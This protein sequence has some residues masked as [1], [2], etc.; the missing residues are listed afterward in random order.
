LVTSPVVV[1]LEIFFRSSP[2]HATESF[3]SLRELADG[4]KAHIMLHR[5]FWTERRFTGLLLILGCLLYY[6]AVGLIPRDAQGNFS[7]SLPPRAA[8]LIIAAQTSLLQWS[9]SLFL[10]GIVITALGFTLL[11]RLL[12]DSEERT[13][14][15]LALITSLFGVM[16]LLIYLA[17]WVGVDPFA[18][19]ETA[20]TGIVPDY[21]LP[22]TMWTT[23]LFRVYTVLAFSALALYGGA[24]LVSRVLP[25]WLS[26]TALLYG[27]AG[28]GLFVFAQDIPPL[29][30]YLLPLVM[31]ILLLRRTKQLEHQR[32]EASPA[33]EPAAVP[34]GER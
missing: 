34:G 3:G 14:S 8:L 17:S 19:Q 9:A 12:W 16:L 32:E 27:L 30:H 20:R 7:V 22:L 5:S 6:A 11:T 13:C 25:R 15:L 24:L 10:S 23:A 29:V 31:G 18:A 4:R 26:W 21:Y 2:R 1:T 28:L 33:P